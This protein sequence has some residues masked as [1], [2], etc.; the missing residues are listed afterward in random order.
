MRQDEAGPTSTEI[1]ERLKIWRRAQ[2]VTQKEYADLLDVDVGTLRKYELGINVPGGLFLA[3]LSAHGLNINWLL[4]GE[5]SMLK[6]PGQR[7]LS[8]ETATRIVELSD[9]MEKLHTTDPEKFNLLMA[10]FIARCE[11]A[12][13]LSY[14]EKRLVHTERSSLASPAPSTPE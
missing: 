1:G 4:M 8:S 11:E 9:A 7:M 5:S 14:L 10:G 12:T 13:H 2:G 3:R 6:Q